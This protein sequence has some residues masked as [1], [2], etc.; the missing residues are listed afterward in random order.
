ML[1]VKLF[2]YKKKDTIFYKYDE[3]APQTVTHMSNI[4]AEGFFCYIIESKKERCYTQLQ[5][6][7]NQEPKTVTLVWYSSQNTWLIKKK[8]N[9]NMF[10]AGI[11]MGKK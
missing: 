11:A 5:T 8:Q 9:S 1:N 2:F 10:I 6:H 3:L 4:Y 7:S